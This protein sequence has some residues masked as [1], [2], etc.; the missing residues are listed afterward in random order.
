[1]TVKFLRLHIIGLAAALIL[2]SSLA[3]GQIQRGTIRGKV[4]DDTGAVLAGATV[5][6]INRISGLSRT[7]VSDDD[8]EFEFNNVPF[9]PYLLTVSFPGFRRFERDVHVHSNLPIEIEAKLSLAPLEEVVV[10]HAQGELVEEDSARTHVNLDESKIEKLPGAAP[11]AGL[12]SLI[13]A[14][15][16]WI[17]DDNQRLH[18]RGSEGH[19]LYV[20]DGVPIIDRLDATFAGS[21]DPRSL[22]SMDIITGSIPAE[23]GNR[24][25]AVI[26][27]QS[28]SG[29]DLPLSGSFAMGAGNFRSGEIGYS[30]G[31]RINERLGVFLS[32][33]AAH[34]SRFLDP[35]EEGNFNNRGGTGKLN[36]RADF[37]PTRNDIIWFNLSVNG[38]NFRVPNRLEQELAG[39][40]QR[41]ELRDNSQSLAWQR[42]LSMNTVSNL[43]VYRRHY[44]ARLLPSEGDTPISAAQR[45]SHTN[46]GIIGSLTH[47]R[48]GHTIKA[49][50]ELFRTP[51]RERFSFEI[52]DP[53]AVEVTE[54]AAKHVRGNPFVFSERR[55]GRQVSAYIQDTFS[56]FKHF[57]VEAGLRYDN[58]RLLVFDQEFS[59]RLGLAY[60]IPR[61]RS[62]VRFSFN[63][64]FQPPQIENLLLA[65]SAAAARLSP[66]ADQ[67][68]SAEIRPDKQWV[69]EVGFAQEVANL[70][71][72]DIAY[73]WKR[74]RNFADRDQFLETA[75]I[76]PISIARGRAEGLEVRVDM[77]EHKGFTG[78]ISY[79]N[80]VARGIGPLNGGL[81]LSEEFEEIGPGVIFPNDHDQRNSVAFAATYR[82]SKSGWWIS[83]TGRF[84]SG[85]PFEFEEEEIE[86]L[87]ER[88]GADLVDFER[89]R[90]KPRTILNLSTGIDLFRKERVG[91][92][93][94]FDIQNLTNKRFLYNFESV[95]GGTH[96]G[97]PRLWSGRLKLT[98]R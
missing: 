13:A 25:G 22:N 83:L 24:L 58:Y 81:F 54:E 88:P 36:L 69:Y 34:S 95:F 57:T 48:S 74:I 35:P 79:S 29:I 6:L 40:R 17:I 39:Q 80:A 43:A 63:R 33:S 10:V 30:F 27:L 94:Q 92:S 90:V 65:G 89:R 3:A 60:F 98:F 19:I 1:M 23:F 42:I 52:T 75:V 26:N 20:V 64:F 71:K 76:F 85:L 12:S 4:I 59:P 78:F 50:F 18:I 86:E 97:P 84:D 31:G 96:F 70:F 11:S 7:A 56:P 49:G 67:G 2:G 8:G 61:T 66:F 15:P 41:Q 53:D 87:M 51:V 14:A 46:E 37:H 44:R 5:S 21:I 32:S 38:T 77:A 68:G 55:I 28:K 16:G 73:F 91:L 45:R 93:W 9:N 72:L 47:H 82:N 62:A